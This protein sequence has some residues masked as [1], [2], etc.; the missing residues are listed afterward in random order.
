MTVAE[1]IKKLQK[2]DQE[3]EVYVDV[4]AINLVELETV[5][6]HGNYSV[7]LLPYE[8][9]EEDLYEGSEIL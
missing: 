1:L 6:T 4:G 7:V 5:V 8:A 2:A 3:R 9:D